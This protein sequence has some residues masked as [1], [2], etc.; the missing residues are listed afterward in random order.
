MSLVYITDSRST[1]DY[2]KYYYMKTHTRASTWLLGGILGYVLARLKKN[3]IKLRLPKVILRIRI[4]K[5]LLK[6][7]F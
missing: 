4:Y 2:A 1:I 7:L 5:I 6:T 3:D